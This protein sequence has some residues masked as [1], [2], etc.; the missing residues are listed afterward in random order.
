MLPQLTVE[1]ILDICEPAPTVRLKPG[2]FLF[3]EGQDAHALYVVQSGSVRVVSRQ[4][5]HGVR[6]GACR[7][8]RRL[9]GT[10]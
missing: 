8:H 4:R 7:R 10:Y 5:Q 2:E 3:H 6:D 1:E 9:D